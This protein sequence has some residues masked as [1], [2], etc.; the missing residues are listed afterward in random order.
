[1]GRLL[2]NVT[3]PKAFEAVRRDDAVFRPAIAAISE[4]LGYKE[5][6]PWRFPDGSLPVYAVDDALVVK[7]Y[8]PFDIAERDT[9][10]TALSAIAGRLPIPTPEVQSSG[11]L[12]GWGYLAMTRLRGQ[13]LSTVWS[14][15]PEDARFGLAEELGNA[16][17]ALHAIDGPPLVPLRKDWSAFLERQNLTA[18]ER[19]ARLGLD[20]SW[21]KQIRGFLDGVSLGTPPS[22]SLLHTE[23]MREHLLVER[24]PRGWRYTGLLDLEP[25]MVGAAEYEFAS[26]GLFF[27]C[28]ESSLLRRVLL[29]YGYR[30]RDLNR[31]LRHRLLAYALL[32]RYSNLPWWLDRLRPGPEATTL[33]DLARAWWSSA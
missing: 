30:D 5:I 10:R 11:E 17:A 12:E 26:V 18:V 20:E 28:G 15:I 2:P 1:M 32:H 29:A 13:A 25:A 24:G 31:D 23:I 7:L 8:P 14:R 22:N 33:E 19:Q 21:L 4:S 27:S 9:E 16:L 6:V 3:T